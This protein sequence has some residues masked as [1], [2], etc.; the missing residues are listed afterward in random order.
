MQMCVV[1]V[2]FGLPDTN[3]EL[4]IS[5]EH[6]G[7]MM[8]FFLHISPNTQIFGKVQPGPVRQLRYNGERSW[9]TRSRAKTTQIIRF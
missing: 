2:L 1:L 3:A 7:E 8:C 5:I 9:R 6:V 4:S